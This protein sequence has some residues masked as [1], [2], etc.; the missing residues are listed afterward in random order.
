MCVA[1]VYYLIEFPLFT[2]GYFT[3]SENTDAMTNILIFS[4]A[5]LLSGILFGAAF[6]SVARSL[7]EDSSHKKHMIIAAYGFVLFYVSGSATAAQSAYSPYGIAAVSF[8]GLSCYLIYLGFYIL[9]QLLCL[10]I[11]RFDFQLERLQLTKQSF[12][13]VWDQP[14][15]NRNCNQPSEILPR[16][17]QMF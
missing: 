16:N 10:K 15:W 7:R 11:Q 8:T 1:I 14:I 13:I 2:L 17:T 9:Q 5:A 4:M 12:W 3:P 6:L